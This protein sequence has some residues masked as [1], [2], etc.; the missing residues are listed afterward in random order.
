MQ[1]FVSHKTIEKAVTKLVEKAYRRSRDTLDL[2]PVA[3]KSSSLYSE[4]KNAT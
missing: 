4:R 3:K 1:V 2:T